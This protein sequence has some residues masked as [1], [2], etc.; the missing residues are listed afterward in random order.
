MLYHRDIFELEYEDYKI[1]YLYFNQILNHIKEFQNISQNNN[2]PFILGG[3][4]SLILLSN[5]I[6]RTP[7]DIDLV[8]NMKD[9]KKWVG[10]LPHEWNSF[11]RRDS[12]DYLPLFLRRKLNIFASIKDSTCTNNEFESTTYEIDNEFKI[13]KESKNNNFITGDAGIYLFR[14]EWSVHNPHE[15]DENEIPHIEIKNDLFRIIFS[16]NTLGD[17]FR[18][19]VIFYD[20]NF[21]YKQVIECLFDFDKKLGRK[22]YSYW[23]TPFLKFEDY[24]NSFYKIFIHKS[25]FSFNML[26]KETNMVL[27]LYIYDD[28]MSN[29][30][31]TNIKYIKL[32]QESSYIESIFDNSPIN[33]AHPWICLN[34]KYGRKKDIDD[35]VVYKNLLDQYPILE[36]CDLT[37]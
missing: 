37:K 36:N 13:Y 4:L 10:C 29:Y 8:I 19:Y 32:R 15:K 2:I 16:T 6:Y 25:V 20:K 22:I 11:N 9:F 14:P 24:N 35:N 3:H 17:H 34:S 30:F 23:S 18:S 28:N 21:K 5:K 1:D 7:K 33:L 26:N 12:I 31:N 27:D